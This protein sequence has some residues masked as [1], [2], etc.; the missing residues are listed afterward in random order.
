M[1]KDGF[2]GFLP[3]KW[4]AA[5]ATMQAGCGLV[6]MFATLTNRAAWQT[7]HPYT[8]LLRQPLCTSVDAI[9]REMK[10]HL[11]IA[12][13]LSLAMTACFFRSS[14]ILVR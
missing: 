13:K 11:L 12:E 2:E 14:I 8:S 5:E 3:G 7:C 4:L 6:M 9:T 10:A 1:Q